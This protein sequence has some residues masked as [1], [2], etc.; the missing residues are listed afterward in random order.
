VIFA[1]PKIV[2]P[3]PDA[4]WD[5]ISNAE[6]S[7]KLAP[8]S[9]DE[10]GVTRRA[11]SSDVAFW[12]T[13]V[14]EVVA[15]IDVVTVVAEDDED[16]VVTLVAGIVVELVAKLLLLIL[17]VIVLEVM[18]VVVGTVELMVDDVFDWRGRTR[19]AAPRLTARTK[20]TTP[21]K[22]ICFLYS[23]SSR[24]GSSRALAGEA[25]YSSNDPNGLPTL[26][27]TMLI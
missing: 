21:P 16:T 25:A 14:E 5:A 9:T 10:T 6:V 27:K 2:S 1:G 3:T 7:L 17:L 24:S 20:A 11:G 4:K 12:V 23:N 15:L 18:K 8:S 19:T 26:L 22:S 13:I